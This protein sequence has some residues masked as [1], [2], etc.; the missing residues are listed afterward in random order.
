MSSIGSKP[1]TV[2]K[3]ATM[4][5]SDHVAM[6]ISGTPGTSTP[7]GV[8]RYARRVRRTRLPRHSYRA[9][10]VRT[11]PPAHRSSAQIARPR[12]GGLRHPVVLLARRDGRVEPDAQL[13][14][15]TPRGLTGGR[16]EIRGVRRGARLGFGGLDR[17]EQRS[18]R[19]H[20]HGP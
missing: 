19:R 3:L 16:G 6:S 11:D 5:K 20:G 9:L 12:A 13:A 17:R 4:P 8:D 14:I 7:P 18:R 15:D 10:A 2:Q 1:D